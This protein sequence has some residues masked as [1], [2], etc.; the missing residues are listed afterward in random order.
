MDGA[1]DG[2]QVEDTIALAREL[3]QRGVDVIDCSS[4]G[5]RGSTTLV[6]QAPEPGFQVPYAAA[7][8]READILTMAVGLILSPRQAEAIVAEGSADLV[9][10]GR[11][12]IADPNFSYHAALE[13]GAPEP[14]DVL[15]QSYSFYLSRRAASLGANLP[16]SGRA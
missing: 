9:A 16:V 8:R 14:H 2:L 1:P 12:L 6:A 4:G 10:L 15:P 5:I 3:K 13:L 7:I 11:Q